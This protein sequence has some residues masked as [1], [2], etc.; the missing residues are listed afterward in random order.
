MKEGDEPLRSFSD[1]MQFYESKRTTP[2][3]DAV[4]TSA[5]YQEE[6]SVSDNAPVA[7]VDVTAAANTESTND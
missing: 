5:N 1:L 7:E 6:Q 3:V 2:E 4:E